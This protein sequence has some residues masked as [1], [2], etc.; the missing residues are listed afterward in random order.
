MLYI[1]KRIFTYLR[2][3]DIYEKN[4]VFSIRH[5]KKF[6]FK[7]YE[8]FLDIKNKKILKYFEFYKNKKSRF[9]KNC[10][11]LTLSLNG[12]LVSSG[13]LYRGNRW[14]ITEIDEYIHSKNRLIIFDFITPPRFRNKGNYTRLLKQICFKFKNKKI[15]IYALSTNIKSKKAIIKA[16][17][18]YRK[19]LKKL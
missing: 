14:K 3:I 1:L 7:V 18:K 11:F 5:S 6:K 2:K 4:R 10:F 16:G 17:F 12:D 15:L 8:K 9:K 19:T 13:W